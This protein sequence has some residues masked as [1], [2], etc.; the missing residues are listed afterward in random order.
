MAQNRTDRTKGLGNTKAKPV[1]VKK[2]RKWCFTLN[3]YTQEE[4][5]NLA[6]DF[7]DFQYI[8][9]KEI[10]D[11]KKT[12]HIQ[13]YVESKHAVAFNTIKAFIPRGHIERCRGTTKSNYEYCSKDGDFITNIDLRT[14][15]EKLNAMC[16]KVYEK[17]KWKNWQAQVLDLKTDTRTIHWYWERKGNVGKTYLCKYLALTRNLILC[18]GKKNDIFNQVNMLIQAEKIPDIIICD[19]PRTSLGFVNYGVL[20]KLKDGMLY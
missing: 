17:V 18:D 16:L 12:P 8:F 1:R 10:G 3:N 20:E 11:D 4:L 13:G 19:I 15:Q 7:R 6:H 14:F 5:K 2:G 9:G